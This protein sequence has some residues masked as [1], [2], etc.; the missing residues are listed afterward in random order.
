MT[1]RTFLNVPALSVPAVAAAASD[2][3]N[4]GLI[5]CGARGRGVHIPG[6]LKHPGVRFT[7]VCDVNSKYMAQGRALAGG[8]RV[9]AYSDY[10]KMLESNDVDAVVIATNQ[11]WHALQT[12]DACRA[13]KDV[14][15][16]KPLGNSIGEGP[17]V[18]EAWRRYG[19][20][21]QAGTQQRSQE[22]YRKAVELIRAGKLGEISEVR[23]WDYENY[24]PG[25]GRPAD[26]APPPELD[27]NQYVG[28][29]A[30]RE[31][32]P[33][34][35]YNYGYDWFRVAGAGHQVAWGVHH[36]DIVLWA[37]G[38]EWPRT[39]FATGGN[40][41]YE[42]NHDYPNTFH[43][44]M[45]FGPGPVAKRGFTLDYTMRTAGRRETRSH[46]KCFVGSAASMVLDRA[47]YSIVRE[48]PKGTRV[49]T[50]AALVGVEETVAAEDDHLYHFEVFLD[51][52]R[53]RKQP[54]ANPE[55][56]HYASAVGHL[57]N[58][59]WESGRSVKWDG[60]QNRVIGDAAAQALV[61]R[62]YRKPWKLGV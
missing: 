8:E 24:W 46:S 23:V 31:Y 12:I 15:L 57:M 27:W 18:V 40:Y 38:V 28:P 6:F 29:S 36:F 30:Y 33:N 51:N 45:E 61:T 1:R 9:A 59:S 20:I 55:T 48:P 49:S 13:G 11:Q 21:V 54:A 25:P 44:V 17:Y 37:M 22:H 19:R 43:A 35:Y 34:M 14:Y 50:A 5:G 42:T 62:A 3:I 52:L 58:V 26:T 39:A 4:L 60:K 32:N 2:T 56:I 53:Q 7:A 41:G 10:R 47:G 16:E